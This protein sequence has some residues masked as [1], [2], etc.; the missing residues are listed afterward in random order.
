MNRNLI[1]IFVL[2]AM[3]SMA[4][5]IPHQLEKRTTKFGKCKDNGVPI[6]PNAG[7][8]EATLTPDPPVAEKDDTFAITA[9]SLPYDVT[10]TTKLAIIF[11]D[12]NGKPIGDGGYTGP[13]CSDEKNC[14]KAGE[15]YTKT[16]VVTVPSPLPSSYYIIIGVFDESRGLPAFGCGFASIGS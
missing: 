14:V 1:L 15:K 7:L 3:L 8:M 4:N 6:V 9:E 16:Q 10:P 11:T 13:A 5:A 2:F 12:K